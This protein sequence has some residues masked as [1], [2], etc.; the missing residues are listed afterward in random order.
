LCAD[1]TIYE[2][3]IYKGQTE[4]KIHGRGGTYFTPVLEYFNTHPEYSC[5]IYFTDGYAEL[6]PNANRPMLWVV[7]SN[8]GIEAIKNHN[9]KILKI[10]K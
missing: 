1:T 5:M 7:S 2:P 10:E 4:I 8:G 3:Y 9:G 6:P